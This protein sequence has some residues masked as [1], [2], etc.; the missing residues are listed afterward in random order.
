MPGCARLKRASSAGDVEVTGGP[1]RPDP[2]AP[3]HD[4]AELV[5]FLAC[6]VDFG[7]DAA[8]SRGDHQPG[9]GRGHAAA[10]A[11]EQRRAQ[12]LLE[13]LDLVRQRRLGEMELLR[14]AREV[15]MPRHRLD[16]SE[17]PKLQAND[18]RTRSLR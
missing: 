15:P 3:A 5:D 1:Q 18:R 8:G 6:G 12:L 9:V 11:L 17:L 4:A 10:R 2:D 13:P 16:A 7:E 14:G